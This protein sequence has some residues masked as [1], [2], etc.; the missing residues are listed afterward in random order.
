LNYPLKDGGDWYVNNHLKNATLKIMIIDTVNKKYYSK[1]IKLE[2]IERII[3]HNKSIKI[4]DYILSVKQ[5]K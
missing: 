3:N 5:Y 2:S 4:E 1:K